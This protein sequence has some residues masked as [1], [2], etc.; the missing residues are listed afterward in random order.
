MEL[1]PSI[2]DLTYVR[3]TNQRYFEPVWSNSRHI[4]GAWQKQ[5]A[6]ILPFQR[7]ALPSYTLHPL[8]NPSISWTLV[9]AKR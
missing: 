7:Q 6:V 4:R 9:Q 1:E 8:Y 2:I 3:L 5:K